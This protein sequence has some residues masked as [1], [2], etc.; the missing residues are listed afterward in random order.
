MNEFGIAYSASKLTKMDMKRA[1][2]G[3]FRTF[4]TI[5]NGLVNTV[6]VEQPKNED[7]Y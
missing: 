6:D 4:Y 2:A 7:I 1:N 5:L 3:N